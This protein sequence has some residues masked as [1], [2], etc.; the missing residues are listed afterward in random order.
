[1]KKS[2][3]AALVFLSLLIA[4]AIADAATLKELQPRPDSSTLVPVPQEMQQRWILNSCEK[5]QVAYRFSDYF[6]MTSTSFGSMV[7]RTG[8]LRDDGNQRYS[9]TLPAE[10]LGLVIGTKGELIQYYGD[11]HAS[12]SIAA[13]EAKKIMLPHVKFQNC[14]TD[15]PMIIKEDPVIVAL[16]PRLDKIHQVC[17]EAE[18]IFKTAC[19]KAVFTLFDDNNDQALDQAEMEKAWK[20]IVPASNFGACGN[21]TEDR[22]LLNADG[23]EYFSWLFTHLDKDGDQK[24]SFPEIEGQWQVMQGDPLMSGATN[25][26]MAAQEP[27]DILPQ[28]MQITCSNCCIAAVRAP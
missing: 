22:M 24:I 25:L 26:L 21:T 28:N 27:L 8:G 23:R 3:L 4:P 11:Q 16:L 18:D 10:T 15:R 14:T 9:L 13:L 1:M 6:M 2:Y 19:Q 17:P 7:Q 12:F 20:M 5:G